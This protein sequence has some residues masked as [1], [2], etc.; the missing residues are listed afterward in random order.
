RLTAGDGA[1]STRDSVQITV[2]PAPIVVERRVAASSDDAEEPASG[3]QINLTSPDLQL[4]NDTADQLVGIRF[5]YLAVPRG[6]TYTNTWIQFEAT[7]AQTS[8]TSL[9]IRAQAADNAGT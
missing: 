9:T 6:A 7:G 3:G 5:P 1:L 2:R 4:I 8:A